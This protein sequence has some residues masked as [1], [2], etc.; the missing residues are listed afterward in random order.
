LRRNYA[1]INDSPSLEGVFPGPVLFVVGGRSTYVE[2]NDVASI[3]TRFPHSQI[4]TIAHAGHWVH[5]E[6]P[7]EFARIVL[8]FLR[9]P[10]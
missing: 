3:R 1:A 5:A 2:R 9:E 6:A 8:E 10:D 7:E 4:V